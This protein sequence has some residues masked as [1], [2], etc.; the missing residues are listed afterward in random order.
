MEIV[1]LC[2]VVK[3]YWWPHPYV[4]HPE[5][6]GSPD[7]RQ[8]YA[9]VFGQNAVLREETQ[10]HDDKEWQAKNPV[11]GWSGRDRG[12]EEGLN[13]RAIDDLSNQCRKRLAGLGSPILAGWEATEIRSIKGRSITVPSSQTVDATHP[14]ITFTT[15]GQ[16]ILFCN[17]TTLV[18]PQLR[19]RCT[20][21]GFSRKQ[22]NRCQGL[23]ACLIQDPSESS[24]ASASE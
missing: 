6:W 16:R 1:G 9:E 15:G 19:S 23:Q 21:A 11:E 20:I 12:R 2:S 4:S 7:N 14:K 5:Q 24:F 22:V 10:A 17:W 3:P 18:A 13:A 8:I